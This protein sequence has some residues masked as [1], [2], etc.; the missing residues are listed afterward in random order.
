MEQYA[1]GIIKLGNKSAVGIGRQHDSP[2]NPILL[3]DPHNIW[4][5]GSSNPRNVYTQRTP[6]T[7]FATIF[8][9]IFK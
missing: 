5:I 2:R 1:I 7:L 3:W 9:K 4:Q 8:E 6:Y